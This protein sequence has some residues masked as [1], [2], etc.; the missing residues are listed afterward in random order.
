MN[1]IYVIVLQVLALSTTAHSTQRHL[2]AK[3]N[4]RTNRPSPP[5]TLTPTASRPTRRRPKTSKR[6]RR[7]I[8][9]S[10]PRPSLSPTA[11]PSSSADAYYWS[12]TAKVT[13]FDGAEQDFFGY[14]V[15]VSGTAAIVG[16]PY[17][18]DLGDSSGSAYVLEKDESTGHWNMVTKLTASDGTAGDVFGFSVSVSGN[19]AIVGAYDEDNYDGTSYVFE[20][21]ES[22]GYW[23]ETAILKPSDGAGGDAFGYSVSASGNT[24]IVGAYYDDENG[25]FSGSVYVFEKVGVPGIWNETAKLTAS[26]AAER[27]FFGYSVSISG[28]IAIVGAY[29]DDENGD[30]SGSAYV[31]E[32]DESTGDW[33]ETAKLTASDGT[34]VDNFGFAVCVSNNISIVSAPYDDDKGSNSGSVYVF[35]K[36]E[37]TGNWNEI[38]KIRASDASDS[39]NFGDSVSVSGDVLI[40][41]AQHESAYV[42]KKDKATGNWNEIDRITASDGSDSDDFGR[43]V[44]VSGEVAIIGASRDDDNGSNSGSV[45][46]FER[47]EG[48]KPPPTVYYW[49]ETAKVTAFD[50]AEQDFFGYSV[51]VSGTA[52]IVGAPYDDDLGD[53]SGSA[54]VL[55]KDES[56]GHWNMVTKLT[57]SNG[58]AGN[59]FGFSV[60]I[61]G[62]IAIVGAYDEEDYDGTSYVFEKDESTG[63]WNETAILKA[64]DGEGYD[65][66]GYSV[67]ASGNT[68]IVGA[69]YDDENGS[70]SGSAYIFEKNA[71]S[72]HWNETAKLIASNGARGDEFG[73]SVSISGNAVVVGS[74]SEYAHVFEKDESTGDW[75]ETAKLTANDGAGSDLFG[76]SVSISGNIAIVG[77]NG[78]DDHGSNSGSV[79]VFEK[80]ESTGDWKETAKL[81]ASD[82]AQE[83]RFGWSVSLSK[84]KAI[85][86]EGTVDRAGSAYVYERDVITGNWKEMAKIEASDGANSDDFGRSVYVS[87]EVAIIGASRDDDDGSNSGSVYVFEREQRE[88]IET[89]K[90]TAFDGAER[91]NYGR[92]VSVSGNAA[93]VGA[94]Y[95]DDLGESSGSA[96]VLEKVESTGYWKKTMKLTASDGTAG[97]VFGWSVSISGNIAIVGAYDE[98][99][100]NGTS[101]VFEKDE[102]TGYW[103]ETAVLEG[104]GGD[105]FGYSVS[106]SGNMAIVGAYYDDENGSYSGAAHMFEKNAVSGHWDETAKLIASDGA[107]GDE[108]GYSVSN[109]GNTAVVG[110]TSGSAYVFEKDETTGEW[111]EAAKLTAS[112]VAAGDLFGSS[113][114]VSGNTIIVGS[115]FDND[116]GVRSGSAYVFEKDDSTG[117]WVETAKLTASDG[118]TFAYF[119]DSVSISGIRAIVGANFDGVNGDRTGS[120][121]VFEKDESTGNWNE[122]EKIRAS[123]AGDSDNFG[124]S[125]SV[126]GDV[127]IVGAQHDDDKGESSGSAYIFARTA[128]ID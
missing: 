91:D 11:S 78:D 5:P 70:F 111:N 73:Y 65:G 23:N 22:T 27:D 125:V 126:S 103:S 102:S 36:D 59:V 79:Y 105:A 93:I 21:D 35:E 82:A 128:N 72:G 4:R 94:P 63:Y 89:A 33:I 71:I 54:Y 30:R 110:S 39:D 86:G 49:N 99:N 24:V 9:P 112:D 62:N 3:A 13:A 58:T 68:V 60:S 55:E 92:S 120:A 44:Y 19:I 87:G 106:V 42:F 113:V 100:N 75:I 37:S 17:D 104:E 16:A 25:S 48:E 67:S 53:S 115:I 43:S 28:N 66:F 45:Y 41:G 51:S 8:Q 97:D 83:Y 64:S 61:S 34:D 47:E 116:L 108:F 57:A 122:I 101:Y 109:S 124:D 88:V 98:D 52:A 15:S 76:R 6:T 18:D 26:D 12:E 90:F 50:G 20:K 119:G 80:D 40:V 121:Y 74:T 81:T 56:T 32:K 29:G 14:S 38:E 2:R 127:F 77:A 46:V 10:T 84:N 114:S 118:T 107:R 31:F 95:D 96:Y 85:I 69:Y 1:F 117:N 123:D 7:P